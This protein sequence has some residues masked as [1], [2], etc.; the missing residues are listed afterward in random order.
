M[1]RVEPSREAVEEVPAY[2]RHAV[3][4]FQVLPS[5]RHHPRP[6]ALVAGALP[7]AVLSFPEAASNR[8]NAVRASQLTREGGRLRPPARNLGQPRRSERAARQQNCERFEE[9]AFALRVGPAQEVEARRRATG[10]GL[11]ITKI[12]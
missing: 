9:I 10:E 7:G 12:D 6:R 11:I 4:D 1:A 8:S 5:K 3:D 2:G